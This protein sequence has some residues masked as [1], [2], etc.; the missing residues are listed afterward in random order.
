MQNTSLRNFAPRLGLAWNILGKSKTVLHAGFGTY[1]SE[2]DD[3]NFRITE[4]YPL[5]VAASF[6]NASFPQQLPVLPAYSPLPAGSRLPSGGWIPT[7]RTPTVQ[8]WSFSI[9]QRIT[10]STAVTV[11]YVGS[12]GYNLIDSSITNPTQSVICPAAPCPAAL[13]AGTQYFPSASQSARLFPLTGTAGLWQDSGHSSYNALQVDARQQVTRG[14]NFRAN[15]TWAKAMDN[16]SFPVGG[17][18]G[19][20]V[21][22]QS[23]AFHPDADYSVSCQDIKYHFSFNG[24]YALPIGQGRAFFSGVGGLTGKLLSGWELNGIVTWQTG[25]PFS[26]LDGFNNSQDGNTGT[27]DRPSWN[28]NFSGNLYPGTVNQWFNPAAFVLGP[29]GTYG[30]VG[31]NVLR[32]PHLADGDIS[33]SKANEIRRE[34]QSD[35]SSGIF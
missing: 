29:A 26:P 18:Q 19:N 28:P 7:A 10:P 17:Y 9:E 1:Y 6:A 15:F 2:L 34:I 3:R 27:P 11:G 16:S 32:G 31:R 5:S 21:N 23:Q 13:P 14:V 33:L 4:A 24:G 8:Q 35:V 20:C 30:N 12:H 22:T 25:L